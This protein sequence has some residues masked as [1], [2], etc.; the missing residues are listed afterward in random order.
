[1]YALRP[2]SVDLIG[3]GDYLVDPDGKDKGRV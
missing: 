3:Q 2:V 1:M